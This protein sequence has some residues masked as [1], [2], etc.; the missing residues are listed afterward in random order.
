MNEAQPEREKMTAETLRARFG[1][2]VRAEF[3]PFSQSR[4]AAD[5]KG[6]GPDGMT[7]NW[8]VTLDHEKR[9]VLT[10]AYSAGIGHCP[11]YRQTL[12]RFRADMAEWTRRECEKGKVRGYGAPILPDAAD[13]V[14][15]LVMDADALD[16]P[17]YESWARDLGFDEDSRKGEATYRACLEIGLK[18]RAALGDAKLAELRE[19]FQDF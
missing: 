11:S 12:S 5:K 10:T 16:C 9:A 17:T 4:H 8:N 18:L 3:V 13:V 6:K 1:L 7:L 14:H 2:T 19:A 15:S